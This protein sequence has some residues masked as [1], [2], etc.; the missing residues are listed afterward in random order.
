MYS[1]NPDERPVKRRRLQEPKTRT[2]SLAKRTMARHLNFLIT[3]DAP[4]IFTSEVEARYYLKLQDLSEQAKICHSNYITH[5]CGPDLIGPT[6][7]KYCEEWDRCSTFRPQFFGKTRII[8]QVFGELMNAFIE[9][10]S[11]KAMLVIFT[12]LF[13]IFII[14][15]LA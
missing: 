3:P 7:Q 13:G 4:L 8:A 9:P 5:K 12:L 15:G 14:V 11:Y 2:E 1:L 6:W 10:L